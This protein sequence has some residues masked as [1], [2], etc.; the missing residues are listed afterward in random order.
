M[1]SGAAGIELSRLDNSTTHFLTED[2]NTSPTGIR[3]LVFGDTS[4]DHDKEQLAS[5]HPLWKRDLFA[6]LEQPKSSS[7]AMLIH[8]LMTSLILTSAIVTVVETVPAFHTISP[9]FWF[10]IETTL[11]AM[12]TVEYLARC[13]AWSSSWRSLLKWMTCMCFLSIFVP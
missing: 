1:S 7:G 12:F 5:I 4:G 10:G 2:P 11:V 13:V 3:Q 9:Q 8:V 6:L